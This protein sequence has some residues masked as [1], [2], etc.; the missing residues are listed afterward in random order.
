MATATATA[1]HAWTS[2]RIG[3]SASL[4]DGRNRPQQRAAAEPE[5]E[6]QGAVGQ[7]QDLAAL[8]RAARPIARPQGQ[9]AA[10]QRSEQA[11]PA[12]PEHDR[13]PLRLRREPEWVAARPRTALRAAAGAAAGTSRWRRRRSPARPRAASAGDGSRPCGEAVGERERPDEQ[14]QPFLREQQ[15]PGAERCVAIAVEDEPRDALRRHH[16]RDRQRA[17]DQ[18]PGHDGAGPPQHEHQPDAGRRADAEEERDRRQQGE[19][20]RQAASLC[21]GVDHDGEHR[22]HRAPRSPSPTRGVEGHGTRWRSSRIPGG[23]TTVLPLNL[24][25]VR[26]AR[27]RFDLLRLR[28][29]GRLLGLLRLLR[30]Q[31]RGRPR[32]AAV[33]RPPAP[34]PSRA[35]SASP[36]PLPLPD[37]AEPSDGPGASPA[38]G[39]AGRRERARSAWSPRTRAR[40]RPGPPAPAREPRPRRLASRPAAI[41]AAVGPRGVITDRRRDTPRRPRGHGDRRGDARRRPRRRGRQR[42]AR[43]GRRRAAPAGARIRRRGRNRRA[44]GRR[45]ADRGD[46]EQLGDGRVRREQ[47]EAGA[48][49]RGGARRSNA[50]AGE[51]RLPQR[52]R[53]D[54]GKDRGERGPLPGDAAGVGAASLALRDV[55]AD[56][57]PLPRRAR[58][59][60]E[61]LLDRPAGDRARVGRAGEP[62]TGLEDER[63]DLLRPHADA[64][65]PPRR[66]SRSPSSV[67][68]SAAR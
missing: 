31:L 45:A 14:H 25:V 5:R 4:I 41:R 66:G 26:R 12:R 20:R 64:P 15:R 35:A 13:Q 19:R 34:A 63:L 2:T 7:P 56:L 40:R 47:P 28:G 68:S 52:R 43:P 55:V 46:R 6:Q 9:G 21:D 8:H 27:H 44:A 18:D 37:P 53:R 54:D 50:E 48:R 61:L 38:R 23:P 51:H 16:D 24:R 60:R 67:S 59:D 33:P 39:P 17:G 49:A 30:L 57:T 11:E 36:W 29:L 65:R 1:S 3:K 10:E 22:P 58:R 42:A 62:P 32:R